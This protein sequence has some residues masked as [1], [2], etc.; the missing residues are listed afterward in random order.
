MTV[1]VSTTHCIVGAVAGTAL[2][3]AHGRRTVSW[4]ALALIA[5]G[6]ALTIGVGVGLTMVTYITLKA[7]YGV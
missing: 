6:W 3:T 2:V 5:C 1:C 4:R 7:I